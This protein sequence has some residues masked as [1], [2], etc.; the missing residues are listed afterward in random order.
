QAGGRRRDDED[1]R[2]ARRRDVRHA[3]VGID[4][5]RADDR[6]AAGQALEGAPPDE[7][8][9][10]ATHRDPDRQPALHQVADECRDLEGGD[11]GADADEHR[12]R[13]TAALAHSPQISL[14][15]AIVSSSTTFSTTWS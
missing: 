2:G 10:V 14:T 7:G 6:R 13:G 12:A 8:L 9:G 4:L 15:L 5:R 11:A 3:A 1:V